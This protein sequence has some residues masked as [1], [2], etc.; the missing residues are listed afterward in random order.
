[1]RKWIPL[2]IVAAALIASAVVYPDLPERMP[3][4]WNLNGEIDGWS[5]RAWGAWLIPTLIAFLWAL[6]RWLPSIDPRGKNYVKFGGA[7]E[8]IMLAVM[9]FMLLVHGLMLR[10]APGYPV[11][12]ERVMPAGIGILFIVIG[13]LLP[14]ARPNWFV[15]IRTPWT[16]SSDRVWEKTHRVGGR[17]FVAGGIILS[18]STFL[19]AGWS[20]VVLIAVVVVCSL[21][22]V[23]YS[24]V[25]W[26]KE[27]G[28]SPAPT[29]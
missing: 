2:L 17:L 11:A 8:G 16:L 21:G 1:M 3:T 6:M 20:R 10:A 14:R 4:H 15:G 18:L 19:G 7:F 24:Y 25:E 26:R 27:K 9:L 29:S 22:A 13:N 23:V 12:M 5:P 28:T